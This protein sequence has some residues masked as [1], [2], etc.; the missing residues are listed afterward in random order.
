MKNF[1][2]SLFGLKPNNENI[3]RVSDDD[4]V[5]VKSVP[6]YGSNFRQVSMVNPHELIHYRGIPCRHQPEENG[7]YSAQISSLKRKSLIN[8]KSFAE[9]NINKYNNR[10]FDCNSNSDVTA[11]EQNKILLKKP[12]YIQNRL[13]DLIVGH[14]IFLPITTAKIDR[15]VIPANKGEVHVSNYPVKRVPYK[16]PINT[17]ENLNFPKSSSLLSLNNAK[18]TEES[19]R[20]KTNSAPDI[21]KIVRFTEPVHSRYSYKNIYQTQQKQD[22]IVNNDNSQVTPSTVATFP[23]A[24]STPLKKDISNG[25]PADL[26]FLPPISTE[27]PSVYVPPVNRIKPVQE[28]LSGDNN[29]LDVSLKN[30]PIVVLDHTNKRN[31]QAINMSLWEKQRGDIP[32]VSL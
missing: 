12:L 15:F 31:D 2:Y 13:H 9:N 6:E 16:A 19:S 30:N 8:G 14:T 18:P 29:N 17:K 5:Y 22:T 21:P 10:M 4:N 1:L 26:F 32:D 23:T 7:Y 20:V 28:N 25:L 24:K 3:Y 11:P 27:K